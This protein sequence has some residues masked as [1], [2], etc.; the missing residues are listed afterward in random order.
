MASMPI[1]LGC[2]ITDATNPPEYTPNG[3]RPYYAFDS[4]TDQLL[5]LG[6]KLP[7]EY[8]SSPILQIEWSGSA[9]TT[10]SQTV[11]WSCEVMKSTGDT[12]G[13][14]VSPVLFITSHDQTTV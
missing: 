7:D 12:D 13:S 3:G 1:P 8:S 11:V 5:Y 2:W 4:G 14:P 9:S 6:F 10:I